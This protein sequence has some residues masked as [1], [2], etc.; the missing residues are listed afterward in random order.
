MEDH[1]QPCNCSKTAAWSE[2][3]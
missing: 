3:G 1:K 2:G